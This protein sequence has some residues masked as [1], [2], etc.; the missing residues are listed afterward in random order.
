MSA[1]SNE[2]TL[3]TLIDLNTSLGMDQWKGGTANYYRPFQGGRVIK[4]VDSTGT[5]KTSVTMMPANADNTG[6]TASNALGN[7]EIQAGTNNHTINFTNNGTTTE[8]TTRYQEVAKTFHFREFGNGGANGGNAGSYPDLSTLVRTGGTHNGAFVMDDGLTGMSYFNMYDYSDYG[9]RRNNDGDLYLTFIGT[10]LTIKGK[11]YQTTVASNLPY[12]THVFR[13][14]ANGTSGSSDGGDW[15][16]DGVLVRTFS[17][18]SGTV[19]QL[20]DYGILELTIHQPKRPAVPEDCVVLADYMLMADF[21]P[22]S[23]F[24]P[25]KISKGVREVDCSR[26]IHYDAA[27]SFTS[28]QHSPAIWRGFRIHNNGNGTSDFKLPFFGNGVIFRSHAYSDRAD[29]AVFKINSDVYDTNFNSSGNY[30]ASN[31]IGCTSP[32]PWDTSNN[33]GTFTFRQ[34]TNGTNTPEGVGVKNLQ[35]GLNELHIDSPQYVVI[36]DAIEVVT[37]IHTSHHYQPFETPFLNELVGGDRNME[38]HNLVVSPDGKTWD[39]LTRDTSYMGPSVM[40]T[41][42]NDNAYNA[43]VGPVILDE[44]RGRVTN[45]ASTQG[46]R[47]MGNKNIAIAYDRFIIL[48]DGTYDIVAQTLT[49]V[50][51][52]VARIKIN[53]QHVQSGHGGTGY[54]TCTNFLRQQ[55]LKRGDY[56]QVYGKWHNDKGTNLFTIRKTD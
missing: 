36:S 29:D 24:G 15:Y 12:G 19:N 25:T 4:W 32:N 53:G 52:W 41:S 13:Q 27:Q 54:E 18:A 40:L 9:L 20:G 39:E 35:L 37:P 5:I 14:K 43:D 7:T 38:Q 55:P 2:A 47:D 28:T 48:V 31:R 49:N 33:D 56:I 45:D 6:S 21:V 17:G 11:T 42:T 3:G 34:G 46:G 10:G 30:S 16:I 22:N 44:L 8:Y 26:D 1:G 23:S 50:A 51:S